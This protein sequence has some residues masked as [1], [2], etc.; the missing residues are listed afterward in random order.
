[1]FYRVLLLI[2]LLWFGIY[3]IFSLYHLFNLSSQIRSLE[4]EIEG[5]KTGYVIY[6][7]RLKNLKDFLKSAR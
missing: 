3:Y 4:K 7:S 6:K 5:Y 2:V 1:M